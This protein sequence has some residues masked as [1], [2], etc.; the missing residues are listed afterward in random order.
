M[1]G[2]PPRGARSGERSGMAD[3][4]EQSA[5]AE[6]LTLQDDDG[7]SVKGG[8]AASGAPGVFGSLLRLFGRGSGQGGAST[9][10]QVAPPSAS[11][12]TGRAWVD[13]A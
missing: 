1:S 6:D 9:V 2:S 13:G 3:T 10:Q 4:D 7:D 12:S 8:S 11:E 5:G